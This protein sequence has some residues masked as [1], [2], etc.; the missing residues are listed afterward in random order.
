MLF[1]LS[2]DTWLLIALA[3][4]A[5]SGLRFLWVWWSGSIRERQSGKKIENPWD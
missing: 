5:I 3:F 2:E 4:L 1:G